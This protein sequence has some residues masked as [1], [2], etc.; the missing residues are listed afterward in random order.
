MG[1]SDESSSII[2]DFDISD[3]VISRSLLGLGDC[4]DGSFVE[5]EQL[6]EVPEDNFLGS[7][8]LE[9]LGLDADFMGS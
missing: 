1:V 5:L 4:L 7:F 3:E 2:K 9:L 6:L 8:V